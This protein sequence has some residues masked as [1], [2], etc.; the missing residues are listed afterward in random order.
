MR[1]DAGLKLQ[2]TRSARSFEMTKN[3]QTSKRFVVNGRAFLRVL[4][5]L[6]G[7]SIQTREDPLDP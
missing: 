6:R 3:C 7:S 1:I 5:V 2:R 4:G